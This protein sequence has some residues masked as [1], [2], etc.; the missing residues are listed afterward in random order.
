MATKLGKM[1]SYLYGVLP[2]MLVNPLV[3]WSYEI[4][5]QTENIISPLPRRISPPNLAGVWLTISG[6]THKVTWLFNQVV[7]RDHVKKYNHYICT[8]PMPMAAKISRMV[9]YLERLVSMKLHDH[10]ITWFCEITW[11]SKIIIYPLPQSLL[12]PNLEGW[13]QTMRSFLP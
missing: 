1:M 5:W 6:P 8:T 4:T 10:I 2:I 7:L 9:T 13:R 12:L 3:M 11:Q